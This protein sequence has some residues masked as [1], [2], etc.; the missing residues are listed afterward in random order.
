MSRWLIGLSLWIW[1]L[2]AIAAAGTAAAQD[3]YYFTVK[4]PPSPATTVNLLDFKRHDEQLPEPTEKYN[5]AKHFGTWIRLQGCYDTRAVVLMRDS[6]V[7]VTFGPNSQCRVNTGS[8]FDPYTGKTFSK[9]S[10]VQIDHVVALKNAYISGAWDWESKTRCLY[11]NFMGNDF[12]LIPVYGPENLKKGDKT[13]ENYMP[14]KKTYSC[15]YLKTWLEIKLIWE[16]A[17]TPSET[18]AIQR[19]AKQSNCSS[20]KMRTTMEEL[21][22][23]RQAIEDNADLCEN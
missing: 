18:K 5:R 10:D 22:K 16:L 1:M 6:K 7:P 20:A 9:A 11:A 12:H 23:S 2:L 13:P 15:Q 4:D 8:W 17:L 14:P 19:I 21:M 3:D